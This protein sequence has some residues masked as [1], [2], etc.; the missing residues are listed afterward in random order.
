MLSVRYC[1]VV[2]KASSKLWPTGPRTVFFDDVASRTTLSKAVSAG[3]IQRLGPKIFSADT[4]SSPEEIVAANWST[5]TGLLVPGA[6]IVDRSA[7]TAGD[8]RDGTL[9][10]AADTTKT[11]LRLPGLDIRIRKG[12]PLPDDPTWTHGLFIASPART[13]IDNLEV[14]RSRAGNV[15]RTLTRSELENWLAGKAIAWGPERTDRL[16]VSARDLAIKTERP[17]HVETIDAMF[18]QLTGLEPPRRDAGQLFVALTQGH[19]WDERR[20]HLFAKAA[21][22][23]STLT[24]PSVPDWLEEADPPGE[25]PF[26]ESYFSNYI[27]GTEFTIEEARTIVERQEPPADRPADGHDILGTY[28]C[29]VDPVGR[30]TTS[31]DP[32]ELI[33]HLRARHLE[34]MRGR[35]DKR[36]GEW[37]T[38]NNQVSTY[39]FVEP[40]LIEGTLRKGLEQIEQLPAGFARALYIM[41]II[42][43][44]H[45]FVDGNGRVARVMMNAELSAIQAARIVI[46]SV[47]RNEYISGLRRVST[48]DDL[49]AFIPI[50]TYAWRWTSS[51]PWADPTATEGQLAATNALL[52]STDAQTS[53]KRLELP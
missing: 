45:P 6:T 23:L 5:I 28:R 49:G 42:S 12:S 37:K 33:K 35:P 25:L 52:D 51:M 14:S 15:S 10:L 8:I 27:E 26:Y 44:V 32:D 21:Q 36:P 22:A 13:L 29:V 3:R 47:Y 4:T 48:N 40:E 24:P 20:Q 7:A 39:Q 53:G 11:R 50:M 41:L 1:K 43:E 34:I 17:Q 31:T 38:K 9:F 2:A 30:A 19:A 16:R 46:P 18:E